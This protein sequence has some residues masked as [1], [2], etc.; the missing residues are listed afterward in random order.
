MDL[1]R[2]LS[3][4]G[5][6]VMVESNISQG[7]AT[8]KRWRQDEIQQHPDD[9]CSDSDLEHI[10]RPGSVR[11]LSTRSPSPLTEECPDQDDDISVT[12]SVRDGPSLN[13]DAFSQHG[14]PPQPIQGVVDYGQRAAP[15][16][17]APLMAPSAGC[18]A[19]STFIYHQSSD[20]ASQ[21]EGALTP[22]PGA[23]ARHICADLTSDGH[24]APYEAA[25]ALHHIVNEEGCDHNIVDQYIMNLLIESALNTRLE[26][27]IGNSAPRDK[28]LRQQMMARLR[29]LPVDHPV[30]K[31]ATK[32]TRWGSFLF[33]HQARSN[34]ERK[35]IYW[36]VFTG[37]ELTALRLLLACHEKHFDATCSFADV[38]SAM[39]LSVIC[40]TDLGTLTKAS[41]LAFQTQM[42]CF[43][44]TGPWEGPLSLKQ[45]QLRSHT[46][47]AVERQME[48]FKHVVGFQIPLSRHQGAPRE[49]LS[50][51]RSVE[52]EEGES[53]LCE[54]YEMI[55]TRDIF[56]KTLM[57]LPSFLTRND[58]EQ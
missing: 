47:T 53:L 34:A 1:A 13:L 31:E 9:Q 38:N 29:S 8:R 52:Y 5:D 27:E 30:V 22:P 11:S 15:A 42:C 58:I 32:H 2:P 12:C 45:N 49:N 6:F 18:Q 19:G 41:K 33:K 3:L 35:H 55:A 20:N 51:G 46:R 48:S 26:C 23:I 44:S 10:S 56:H 28:N 14:A 21:G 54:Y 25:D 40:Q 37:V 43:M 39:N 17:Q 4:S 57:N 7:L 24:P 50:S 16:T 36:D